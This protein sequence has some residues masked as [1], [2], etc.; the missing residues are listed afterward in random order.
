MNT[1]SIIIVSSLILTG[2][3]TVNAQHKNTKPNFILILA[4][5]LGW[6]NTSVQMDSKNPDSKSDYYYTPNIE[7]MAEKG[8]R[9]TQ[10]YAPAAICCPTRRSIQF[11]QTPVRQGEIHYKK[12]YHPDNNERITIPKLLKLVEPDYKTAHYGKWDLRAD[13]FPEDL[14]YDESDGN[15]G[16]KDGNWGAD[17]IE[18]W[19]NYFFSNDPKKINSLT[20]RAENFMK[21]Q[22]SSGNPFYLQISHYATH[23][24][25]QTKESTLE[26]YWRKDPGNIHGNP[27]FA[28]MLEDLDAGI[29]RIIDKVFELGIE[30]NTWI[31]LMTDNGSAELIPQTR[32][33]MINPAEYGR[34]RLN[35]PLRGGKWTLYEGGIRVPFIVMGPDVS[36]G[37]QVETPTAGWDIL[38]TIADLAGYEKNLPKDIDGV[39]LKEALTGNHNAKGNRP[40]DA[41][42]FHRYN[43]HYPHSAIIKGD[44][45]LVKLWRTGDTELYNLSEDLGEVDNISKDFPE[46]VNELYNDLISYFKMVNAEILEKYEP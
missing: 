45:K 27:G 16:N 33:K 15:T 30:N 24:E 9:F 43:D 22:V 4:D 5:D 39:S 41:L 35:Y 20:D 44:Y 10:A 14:G 18:K 21:R 28:A 36:G 46:K 37:L 11:G 26:K 8:I 6:S 19:T 2:S 25:I 17:N 31:F 23:V 7:R 42:F 40:K 29:G 1:K 34:P 32:H 12:N 13:I 38:P 3:Y